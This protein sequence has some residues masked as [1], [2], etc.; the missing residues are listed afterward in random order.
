MDEPDAT[1]REVADSVPAQ[2]PSAG[3][4]A[5]ELFQ[6]MSADCVADECND[7]DAAPVPRGPHSNMIEHRRLHVLARAT[8]PRPLM[9]GLPGP[10]DER[11]ACR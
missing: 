8:M 1:P 2:A 4:T 9:N 5:R 7:Y 3:A 10:T 6:P 11:R